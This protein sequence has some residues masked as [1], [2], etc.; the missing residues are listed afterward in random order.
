[1]PTIHLASSIDH[2]YVQINNQEGGIILTKEEEDEHQLSF[3]DCLISRTRE[4]GFTSQVHVTTRAR[5]YCSTEEF[6]KA[7]IGHISKALQ[8]N[9]YPRHFI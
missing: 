1:M 3:L 7:E 9:N 6:E 8:C 4:G 5:K 2:T